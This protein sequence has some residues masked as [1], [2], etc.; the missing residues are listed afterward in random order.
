MH[1]LMPGVSM[2]SSARLRDSGVHAIRCAGVYDQERSDG[3]LISDSLIVPLK[4]SPIPHQGAVNSPLRSL[5]HFSIPRLPGSPPVTLY[6][7]RSSYYGTFLVPHSLLKIE[8]QRR[9]EGK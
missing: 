5:L 9:R 6:S 8:T 7:V 1:M 3:Y 4:M 2:D